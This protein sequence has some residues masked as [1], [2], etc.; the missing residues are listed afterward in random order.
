MNLFGAPPA[1]IKTV[2]LRVEFSV[3]IRTNHNPRFTLV[4]IEAQIDIIYQQSTIQLWYESLGH[5]WGICIVYI[6]L[7]VSV[8][9]QSLLHIRWWYFLIFAEDANSWILLIAH[10]GILGSL[11]AVSRWCNG[12][13]VWFFTMEWL[14]LFDICNDFGLRYFCQVWFGWLWLL[15]SVVPIVFVDDWKQVTNWFV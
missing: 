2:T 12:V 4:L 5:L 10:L 11:S 1:R 7:H 13:I 9:S 14:L 3:T 15:N 6:V 8:F